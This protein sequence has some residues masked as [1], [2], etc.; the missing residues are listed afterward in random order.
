MLRILSI[1]PAMIPAFILALAS[2]LLLA[3]TFSSDQAIAEELGAPAVSSP[4]V[5]GPNGKVSLFG[6]ADDEDVIIYI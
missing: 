6:G 2:F 5:S 3:F 1:F 4:A